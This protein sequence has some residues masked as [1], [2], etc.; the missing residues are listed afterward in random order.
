MRPGGKLHRQAM[1]A[2]SAC[3]DWTHCGW[4]GFLH[5]RAFD[6]R[7]IRRMRPGGKLHRQAMIAASVCRDWAAA[8]RASCTGARSSNARYGRQAARSS[9]SSGMRL[10][11]QAF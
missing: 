10:K 1:I 8:D 5:R 4:S 7:R 11:K 3:K 6:V 9:P 2:A